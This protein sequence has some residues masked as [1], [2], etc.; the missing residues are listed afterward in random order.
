[1]LAQIKWRIYY[2]DGTTVDNT[3]LS[4]IHVPSWNLQII[5]QPDPKENTVYIARKDFYVYRKIEQQWLGIDWIGLID[6]LA[7]NWQDVGGFGIGRTIPSAVYDAI[8]KRAY[9]DPDFYP[10]YAGKGRFD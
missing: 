7:H 10:K 3:Q 6:I 4:P 1:M 8:E 2:G 9:A 5:V